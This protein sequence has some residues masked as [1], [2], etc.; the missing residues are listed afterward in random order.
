MPP[1]HTI[2]I[3][4]DITRAPARKPKKNEK[5]QN[6]TFC[7]R[8]TK[9]NREKIYSRCGDCNMKDGTKFID[10]A[11]KMYIGVHCMIND[12]D[13][14]ARGRGNGTLCR[15][16]SMKL[17]QN[18]TPQWRNYENKKVYAVNARDVEYLEFEHFPKK[19]E[20]VKMEQQ[21]TKTTEML[22]SD[23]HNCDL[24]LQVEL[25]RD[26]ISKHVRSRRFKLYSKKYY[27][28]F[29]SDL[30]NSEDTG[31]PKVSDNNKKK[32]KMKVAMQQF[33]VNLNDATTAHK[34]Q[35]C[36]K[37]NL[38]VKDWF[39]SH[40]WVYTVLSHVRTLDGLFLMRPLIFKPGRFDIPQALKWFDNRMR[41]K[42]PEKV[43]VAMAIN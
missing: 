18:I 16:V 20:L 32:Q 33:P 9:N 22:I 11:L 39:Y 17:R 2:V 35:G 24:A 23:P 5:C 29:D 26:K 31:L 12:N 28:T 14:I 34:L 30:V 36:S 6:N 7:P 25:L 40:G 13:D 41:S 19:I 42:I 43:K 38:I 10:P 4:A 1:S 21:L 8:V 3:E 27:C 15:L 37:N